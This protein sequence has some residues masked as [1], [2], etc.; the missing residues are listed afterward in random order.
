MRRVTYRPPGGR[1][2]LRVDGHL[3]EAG[4][5]TEVSNET[6]RKLETALSRHPV[7]VEPEPT[8][9]RPAEG[10][11]AAGGTDHEED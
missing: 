11:R 7:E 5:P 6:A 2:R 10:A 4:V 3:L 8:T 9:Q 1:G